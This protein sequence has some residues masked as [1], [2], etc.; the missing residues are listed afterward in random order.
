MGIES[1]NLVYGD[2]ALP[3][4]LPSQSLFYHNFYKVELN[5]VEKI[6]YCHKLSWGKKAGI[7]Y[8]NVEIF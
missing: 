6:N 4:K 8:T 5:I 3:T 7:Y 1:E 2:Y